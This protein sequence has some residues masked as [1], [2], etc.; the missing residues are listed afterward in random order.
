MQ[1]LTDVGFRLAVLKA[2]I[3]ES[4]WDIF[5][6]TTLETVVLLMLVLSAMRSWV[7][8]FFDCFKYFLTLSI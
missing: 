6:S 8:P 4:V 3:D 1:L 7:V 2:A 5:V